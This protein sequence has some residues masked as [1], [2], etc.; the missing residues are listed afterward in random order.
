MDYLH[1]YIRLIEKRRQFPLNK[2]PGICGE[3]EYHHIIPIK[4]DGDPTP[5]K[6]AYN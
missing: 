4:C 6:Q 2:K 5:R 1:V 3:V